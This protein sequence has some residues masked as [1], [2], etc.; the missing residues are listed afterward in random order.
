MSGGGHRADAPLWRGGR[1]LEVALVTAE[2][3]AGRER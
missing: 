3:A 1:S 2:C